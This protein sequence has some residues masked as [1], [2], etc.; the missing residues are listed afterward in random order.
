MQLA[1]TLQPLNTRWGDELKLILLTPRLTVADALH[2][3]L[4]SLDRHF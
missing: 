1:L 4:S 3:L 2:N